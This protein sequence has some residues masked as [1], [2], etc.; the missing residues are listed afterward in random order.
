MHIL[1]IVFFLVLKWSSRQCQDFQFTY[2][3][4][5]KERVVMSTK[6]TNFEGLLCQ[7]SINRYMERCARITWQMVAQ[8][9][10]MWLSTCDTCFDEDKH[11]LWWSC[12]RNEASIIKYFVWPALYDSK[13]GN[14][15]VKGCVFTESE[16]SDQ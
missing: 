3:Q 13:N 5:C 10:A 6:W 1:Y 12:D 2:F 15:L 9:T 14:L 8:Q 11:K 16:S 7:K 4:R